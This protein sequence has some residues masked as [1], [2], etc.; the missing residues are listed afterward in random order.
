MSETTRT[1]AV[2]AALAAL[3]L[4]GAGLSGC[5]AKGETKNATKITADVLQQQLTE[6]F[7]GEATPPKSVS[8]KDDLEGQVGKTATCDVTLNDT[9]TVEAVVTVNKV[10]GTDV[11]YDVMPAL[12]KE[13]L[14]NAVTAM[15]VR[16]TVNC[17]TGLEGKIGATAQCE[18]TVD[19]TVTKRIVQVDDVSGLEMDTSVK[20]LL[21][22]DKVGAVLLQKLNANGQAVETVECVDDVEAKPGT[23]VECAAVT[24]NQK[25]GYVVTVTTVEEDSFDVDYKDAP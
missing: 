14:Q 8:C 23:M 15:G 3:G 24:G 6:Q 18:S 1:A 4:L 19:G 20:R 7:A 10:D 12:S 17:D 11:S 25:T 21:P 22:K 2:A 5:S 16:G 13:Q 9:S